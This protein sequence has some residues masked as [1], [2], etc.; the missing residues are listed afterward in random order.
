MI[1]ENTS[2]ATGSDA[3]P[4]MRRAPRDEEE[5]NSSNNDPNP[6]M[7]VRLLMRGVHGGI[8]LDDIETQ[9]GGL[10]D[11]NVPDR[12]SGMDNLDQIAEEPVGDLENQETNWHA[13]NRRTNA[14]VVLHV[15][16]VSILGMSLAGTFTA[17]GWPG[18]LAIWTAIVGW[19]TLSYFSWRTWSAV[20]AQQ[21]VE[22]LQF[23]SFRGIIA[24]F[25]TQTVCTLGTMADCVEIP[26]MWCFYFLVGT[27]DGDWN[28]HFCRT[29]WGAPSR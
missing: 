12:A 22:C 1:D 4:E 17:T 28:S 25:F 2:R 14:L 19:T 23:Q 8:V 3:V 10:V 18:H 7:D 29:M 16:P 9:N 20:D 15:L 11:E 26:W 5:I 6:P 21:Q 27:L 13:S 24:S